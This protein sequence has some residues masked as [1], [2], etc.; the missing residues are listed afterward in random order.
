MIGLKLRRLLG[1]PGSKTFLVKFSSLV[2][3]SSRPFK[4]FRFNFNHWPEKFCL[5]NQRNLARN[6][7]IFF[8]T[9]LCSISTFAEYYFSRNL[10]FKP[11]RDGSRSYP[12]NFAL[13]KTMKQRTNMFQL[14]LPLKFM[15]SRACA[16][17]LW[18]LSQKRL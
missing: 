10:K 17:W 11:S 1:Y 6:V 12:T 14:V 13:K 18:Q 16:T 8:C 2:L 15:M 5:I 4:T 7:K 3:F 9:E